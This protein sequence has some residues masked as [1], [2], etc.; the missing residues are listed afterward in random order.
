ML[1]QRLNTP[2]S[3]N[4]TPIFAFP[5]IHPFIASYNIIMKGANRHTH[6]HTHT[7]RKSSVNHLGRD[8]VLDRG[9]SKD[10]AQRAPFK[11]VR[12]HSATISLILLRLML[13]GFHHDV[14]SV[15][16]A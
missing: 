15:I 12:L 14:I 3:C 2:V 13:D 10:S 16:V 5:Y 1:S 9:Q 11:R 4:P 8:S 7:C 6:T